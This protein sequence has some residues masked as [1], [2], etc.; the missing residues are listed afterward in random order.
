MGAYEQ[1]ADATQGRWLV[2]PRTLCFVRHDDSVLLMKRGPHKRVFPNRYNGL[3]GH[4]EKYEDPYS[5]ALREIRE[6]SGLAVYNLRLRSIHN[7]DAGATGGILLFVF[8]AWSLSLSINANSP[9]GTLHWIPLSKIYELELVEDLP[10]ILPKIFAMSDSEPPFS[11]HIS[12]D[13]DDNI[14]MQFYEDSS[15]SRTD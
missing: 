10:Y 5:S 9:E 12:Y 3:G 11:V 6:E 1:G 4:I 13:K 2:I 15:S 7:I 8:T 14:L